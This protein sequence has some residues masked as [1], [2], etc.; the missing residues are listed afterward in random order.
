MIDDILDLLDNGETTPVADENT[1]IFMPDNAPCHHARSVLDFLAQHH[2]PVIEWAPQSLDLNPPENLWT[3]FNAA[4][5]KR[6]ADLFSRPS[7]SLEAHYRYG[8]VLQDMQ[9]SQGMEIINPLIEPMPWRVQAV[10]A[11]EAGCIDY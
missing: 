11:A 7:K 10:L 5:H 1:F 3:L 4:F 2:V 8:E 6:F 9:Y